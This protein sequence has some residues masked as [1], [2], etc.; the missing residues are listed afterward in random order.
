MIII[1]KYLPEGIAG[2]CLFP[3][4]F[5]NKNSSPLINHEKIH[6]QQALE[7]FV[8]PFYL[9]YCIEFLWN[10]HNYGSRRLAYKM[11]SFEREAYANQ[12]NPSYLRER[13]K[14]S[15]LKY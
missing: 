11:L 9:W 12:H 13:K 4:I 15:F 2:I 10:W 1:T 7:L 14:Y 8:V 5:V 3:F 6:Y